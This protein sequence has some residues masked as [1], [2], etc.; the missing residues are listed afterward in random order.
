MTELAYRPVLEPGMVVEIIKKFPRATIRMI[1][2][3]AFIS[4]RGNA[5]G[6]HFDSKVGDGCPKMWGLFYIPRTDVTRIWKFNHDYLIPVDSSTDFIEWPDVEDILNAIDG[7]NK[8]CVWRKDAIQ[9]QTTHKETHHVLTKP[10]IAEEVAEIAIDPAE[11]EPD[12]NEALGAG[13]ETVVVP[14]RKSAIV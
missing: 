2:V 14:T 7:K 9:I 6:F 5:F 10:K 4:K 11:I 13:V 12:S 8:H 1:M 3:V